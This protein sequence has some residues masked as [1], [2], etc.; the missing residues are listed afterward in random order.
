MTLARLGAR[1]SSCA[2]ARTAG[3]W[4]IRSSPSCR[5]GRL[6]TA[7]WFTTKDGDEPVH[8]RELVRYIAG[9]FFRLD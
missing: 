8:E 4:G 7:Y 2:M 3:T 9:T 1:S 5:D 6:F